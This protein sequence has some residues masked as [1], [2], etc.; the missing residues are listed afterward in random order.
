MKIHQSI[1][2]SNIEKQLVF[3][4]AYNGKLGLLKK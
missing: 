2:N 4:M 1:Y 3:E